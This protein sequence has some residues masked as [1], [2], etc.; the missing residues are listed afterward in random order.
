[1]E[2]LVFFI[3]MLNCIFWYFILLEK[4]IGHNLH[5]CYNNGINKILRF[6]LVTYNMLNLLFHINILVVILLIN[7]KCLNLNTKIYMT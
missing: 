5:F 2:T 4:I 7:I 6:H 3:H 1:V